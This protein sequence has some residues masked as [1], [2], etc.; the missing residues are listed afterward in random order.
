MPKE[1]NVYV[2]RCLVLLHV[3]M[4]NASVAIAELLISLNLLELTASTWG[5]KMLPGEAF[6][7]AGAGYRHRAPCICSR[8]A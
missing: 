4:E 5:D 2:A 7:F 1:C 8:H 6:W 3:L